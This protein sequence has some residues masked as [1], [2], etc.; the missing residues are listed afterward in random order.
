MSIVTR[1]EIMCD[2]CHKREFLPSDIRD[3]LTAEFSKPKGWRT[4]QHDVYGNCTHYCSETCEIQSLNELSL[5]EGG[6]DES[7]S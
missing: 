3:T 4:V 1:M 7:D 5:I 2:W 6:Y